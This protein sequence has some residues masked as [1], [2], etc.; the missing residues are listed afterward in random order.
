[1]K[2]MID[3]ALTDNMLQ[4]TC[5]FSQSMMPRCR[6]GE[7]A[8]C[9]RAARIGTDSCGLVSH[10]RQMRESTYIP[11]S[12]SPFTFAETC[13]VVAGQVDHPFLLAFNFWSQKPLIVADVD[14][15]Y[16]LVC[17]DAT[18][19]LHWIR[20]R[21]GTGWN[22]GFSYIEPCRRLL[23]QGYLILRECCSEE[24]SAE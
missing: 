3:G 8:G 5:S 15:L 22:V 6:L 21:G 12:V 13:L 9:G 10:G 24:Q 17:E 23:F 20:Y 1:M 7:P 11:S 4:S 14:L 19:S 2:C 18:S 16:L